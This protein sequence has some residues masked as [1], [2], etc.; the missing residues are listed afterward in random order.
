MQMNS[1]DAWQVRGCDLLLLETDDI[2]HLG[3]SNCNNL[4]DQCLTDILSRCRKLTS[5]DLRGCDKVSDV[6]V[7]TLGAGCGQLLSI[8]LSH[9]DQVKIEVYQHWVQDVVSCRASTLHAVTR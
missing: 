5:I 6:G 1:A 2:V 4:T 7:S 8:N 9:C 3:L